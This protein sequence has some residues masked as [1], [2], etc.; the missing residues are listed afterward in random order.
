[1]LSLTATQ[2]LFLRTHAHA[3]HPVVMIGNAGLSE[4]VWK[5]LESSLKSHE[6]IKIKVSSDD[7]TIREGVLNEICTKLVAAPVQHIGKILVI[8]KTAEKPKLALPKK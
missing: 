5:E 6:L 4:A 3:L 2:R 7:K 8:Y 1:M